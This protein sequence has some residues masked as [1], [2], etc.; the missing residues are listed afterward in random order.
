MSVFDENA[1]VLRGLAGKGVDLARPRSID[2]SHV[3]P[4]RRSA[5]A[6]AD[7]LKREG[8]EADVE[9]VE[10]EANPWDVTAS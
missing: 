7:A 4:D 3:F 8:L 10:R 6:F 5:Q 2:F 1:E 9:K